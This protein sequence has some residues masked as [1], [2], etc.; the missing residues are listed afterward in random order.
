M[1]DQIKECLQKHSFLFMQ[2]TKREH[3]GADLLNKIYRGRHLTM[4]DMVRLL[5]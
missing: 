3:K 1:H 2:Q 4:Q 5:I